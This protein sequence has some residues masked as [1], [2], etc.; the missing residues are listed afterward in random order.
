[1]ISTERCIECTVMNQTVPGQT[2][3]TC[4]EEKRKALRCPPQ[5]FHCDYPKCQYNLCFIHRTQSGLI[6]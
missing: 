6:R 3:E 1:M 5:Y 4:R 2:C